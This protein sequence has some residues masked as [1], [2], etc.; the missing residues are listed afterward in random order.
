MLIK[1]GLM[2]QPLTY[3]INTKVR[4]ILREVVREAYLYI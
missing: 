1:S 3:D 2:I 4:G